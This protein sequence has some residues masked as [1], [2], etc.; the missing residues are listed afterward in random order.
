MGLADLKKSSTQSDSDSS[1]R[2]RKLQMSLDEF[3]DDATTYAAGF[4]SSDKSISDKAM[5]DVIEL[6]SHFSVPE[7]QPLSNT[8][9]RSELKQV[10]KVLRGSEPFRKATFTLS[11]SAISHLAEL[12]SGCD[13]AKSKLIRFLIEHHFS[14]GDDERREKE[15]SIIVD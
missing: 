1:A 9:S 14:L 15:R 8:I 10:K 4:S 6:A 3:I 2:T 7:S 12:A 5:A 11:E 13:I